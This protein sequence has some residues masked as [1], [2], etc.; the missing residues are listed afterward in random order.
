MENGKNI[1]CQGR[2][3]DAWTCIAEAV[4]T[5]NLNIQYRELQEIWRLFNCSN[6][7]NIDCDD[8]HLDHVKQTI[9]YITFH[10]TEHN[11]HSQYAIMLW[12]K[13]VDLANIYTC[14]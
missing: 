6:G 8:K 1:Q 12:Q 14:I 3:A 9:A 13:A 11:I 10:R 4:F 7:A 5:D 2:Q